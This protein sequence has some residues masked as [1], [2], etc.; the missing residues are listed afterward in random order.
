MAILV[1]IFLIFVGILLWG[2]ELFLLT[3][4]IVAG[5]GGFVCFIAAICL[6]F[7]YYGATAGLVALFCSIIL[8]ISFLIL[9]FRS[10]IWK[11]VSLSST[12][13]GSVSNSLNLLIKVGD[14]GVTNSRLGPIGIA[15][16]EGK[17]YEVKSSKEL[18]SSGTEVIVIETLKDKIIVKP[19]N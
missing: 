11:K 9:A 14:K 3:G 15:T 17:Q 19:L 13:H 10:S 16:F 6:A 18:I 7:S 2:I 4:G 1:I 5:I 8:F 12:I